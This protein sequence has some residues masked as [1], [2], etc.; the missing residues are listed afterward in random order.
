MKHAARRSPKIDEKLAEKS[1]KVFF[2]C[3]LKRVRDITS[4][5][6]GQQ[7]NQNNT[8]EFS[9]FNLKVKIY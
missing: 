7:G 4:D 3:T 9:P 5:K 2:L 1:L 6:T 8:T